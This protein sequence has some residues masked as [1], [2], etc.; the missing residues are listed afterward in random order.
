MAHPGERISIP[1]DLR[2]AS[3]LAT[4][5]TVMLTHLV[6]TMHH[7]IARRPGI[8]GHAT[9][10]PLRG[11]SGLVYRTVRGVTRLVG[12]S[13]DGLLR[14]LQPFLAAGSSWPGRETVLAALN[15]VLGDY[16]QDSRNPLA[17]DMLFR[18]DGVTL[19]LTADGLR[20][21]LPQASGKIAV[22]VHG[23][24]M[25]DRQWRRKGH[26]HGERLALD[27]GFTPV[28]LRY[29]SGLHISTNGQK[30]ASLL[31]RLVA[32]WPVPVED[33]VIIGHS[34]GGLVA[35]SAVEQGRRSK[36]A[37]PKRLHKLIFLGTPHHGAPL[38]RGGAWTDVL[39]SVSPYT[40]AFTH[41]GRL[42]S[43]G[44][45]DLRHGSLLDED[46]AGADRFAAITD[47]RR[48]VG[49]PAGVDCFAI[50]GLA[51]KSPVGI[52]AKVIGDGLVPLASALGQHDDEQR[53]LAFAQ[54]RQWIARRVG[55]LELLSSRRVYARIRRWLECGS[56]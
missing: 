15:G 47:R 14:A 41:L 2:G 43:A 30:L 1:S 52:S 44:I 19:E 27:L 10:A 55:H 32:H 46:W 24:C 53:A 3:R 28:Y 18:H 37:W 29:N 49:L 54:D 13:L 22:L 20:Q 25:S 12:T 56:A 48:S 9:F 26:D 31:E 7:N 17:I 23:L 38:E 40:A 45:T 42:R 35:R 51:A 11:I 50:A 34:M 16:L 6:E 8:L 5:T 33:V 4:D 36:R 39:F 21:A